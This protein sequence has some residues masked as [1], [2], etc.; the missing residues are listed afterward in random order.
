MLVNIGA[1]SLPFFSCCTR[2]TQLPQARFNANC[3][4]CSRAPERSFLAKVCDTLPA[5]APQISFHA[6]TA[7]YRRRRHAAVPCCGAVPPQPI[8]WKHDELRG[9]PRILPV[10]KHRP[11]R[12][13]CKFWV[14]KYGNP[15]LRTP[16]TSIWRKRTLHTARAHT[17][18]R[19]TFDPYTV[20]VNPGKDQL[21][22]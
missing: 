17:N 3:S 14:Q 11:N 15:F 8:L 7:T 4:C 18:S 5:L 16:S 1:F 6:G 20:T 22:F 2:A 21:C 10:F 19:C 12:L 13:L 9:R